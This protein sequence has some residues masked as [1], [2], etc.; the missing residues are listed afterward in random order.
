MARRNSWEDEGP[1]IKNSPVDMLQWA[2]NPGRFP[3]PKGIIPRAAQVPPFWQFK[4]PEGIDFFFRTAGTLAAGAGSTL[5]LAP[6]PRFR[7]LPDYSGV[8]AGVSIFVDTPL[9]TLDITFTLRW[10]GGPVQGWDQLEAF[11]VAANAIIIP[12]PGNLQ[13]PGGTDVDVLVTNNSAAG[14]WTVG[15]TVTGWQWAR[16]NEDIAFGRL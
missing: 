1:D 9:T 15:A 8:I 2:N 12:F 4:P 16:I 14:P 11:P 10:N 3:S 5:I 7:I 6:T 13:V